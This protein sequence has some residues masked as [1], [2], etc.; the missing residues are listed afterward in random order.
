VLIIVVRGPLT[1]DSTILCEMV[2]NAARR[3]ARCTW[4]TARNWKV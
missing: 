4:P 2:S 3:C 1:H